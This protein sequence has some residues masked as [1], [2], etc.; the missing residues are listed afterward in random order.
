MGDLI[1]TILTSGAVSAA[2]VWLA[3]NLISH[4][5]KNAIEHEYARKLETHKAE[6]QASQAT[7][8]E[9]M[10]TFSTSLQSIQAAA[11]ASFSSAHLI[12]SE[13]RLEAI[14]AYWEAV[15]R[16]RDACPSA[17][18]F[19]DLFSPADLVD[20]KH[21][22]AVRDAIMSMST[23]SLVEAML[24]AEQG[25]ER[26]RPFAGEVV[27][28][29]F[30]AYRAFIGRVVVLFT[31]F[32]GIEAIGTWQ[33]DSGIRQILASVVSKSGMKHLQTA[34]VGGFLR[35]RSVLEQNFLK[36]A[37]DVV[38]GHV[39]GAEALAQAQEILAN[40][41]EVEARDKIHPSPNLPVA[42]LTS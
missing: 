8:M 21:H 23:E 9:A 16:M 13:R 29:H 30:F 6:L 10:R 42:D 37:G 25:V 2:I 5:L 12:A 22:T 1:Q 24:K 27:H 40:I 3:R 4:R 18:F 31:D 32:G 7:T 41:Q 36:H 34:P 38:S 20:A 11:T 39:A 28:A 33:S 35:M 14:G 17:L 15:L 19:L 26:W